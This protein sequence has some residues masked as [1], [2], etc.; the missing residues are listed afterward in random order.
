MEKIFE[1]QELQ[2]ADSKKFE[3]IEQAYKDLR[4]AFI[5]Q[6]TA[7]FY[8]AVNGT[9]LYKGIDIDWERHH[10]F[11]DGA[12]KILGDKFSYIGSVNDFLFKAGEFTCWDIPYLKKWVL[13]SHIRKKYITLRQELKDLLEKYADRAISIKLD[14]NDKT[15]PQI[16]VNPLK[17]NSEDIMRKWDTFVKTLQNFPLP[18]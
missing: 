15:N 2:N 4:E 5:I 3:E 7:Q 6:D 17:L 11:I 9:P 13:R 8:L 10:Q 12:L 18:A 1:S 16:V 14:L